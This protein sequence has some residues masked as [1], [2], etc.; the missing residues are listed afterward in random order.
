MA[1][2]IGHSLAGYAIYRFW[3]RHSQDRRPVL[4][5]L[6]LVLANAADLDFLPGILAGTPAAYH[7]GVSHSFA[8]ALIASTLAAAVLRATFYMSAG[9]VFLL[10]F[11]CYSSH[12]VIDLFGPDLRPPF[13]IP[14]FWPVSDRTFLSP[15]PVFLGAHHVMTASASTSEW[16]RE[17]LTLQNVAAVG[18]EVVIMLPF[19]FFAM[20]ASAK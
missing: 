8:L 6:A 3:I 12:L 9:P 17:V 11:L 10:G 13:G 2:P 14:L 19:I 7:Q 5:L 4:L 18:L 20:R 15:V 1:T 16:V